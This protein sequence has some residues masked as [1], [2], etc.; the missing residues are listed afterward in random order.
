MAQYGGRGEG[1]GSTSRRPPSAF[2]WWV[3]KLSQ[4]EPTTHS[5][6]YLEGDTGVLPEGYEGCLVG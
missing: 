3:L 2:L 4:G 1:S 5:V 6:L